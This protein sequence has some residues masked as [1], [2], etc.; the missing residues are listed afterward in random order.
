MHSEKT[1]PNL[2]IPVGRFG[3][4]QEVAHSVLFLV[5]ANASFVNGTNLTVDGGQSVAY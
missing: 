2:N 3:T 5:S 1:G 4:P